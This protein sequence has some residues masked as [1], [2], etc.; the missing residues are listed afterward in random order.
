MKLHTKSSNFLLD[1]LFRRAIP[2]AFGIEML[3][4]RIFS[5]THTH[6]F[7]LP[8]LIQCEWKFSVL[9]T[10]PMLMEN[11]STHTYAFTSM[12]VYTNTYILYMR[13]SA[14]LKMHFMPSLTQDTRKKIQIQ[15]TTLCIQ[16]IRAQIYTSA[17]ALCCLHSSSSNNIIINTT[18]RKQL[19]I[20]CWKKKIQ[21]DFFYWKI[22]S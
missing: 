18:T 3:F 21:K 5:H 19:N 7:Y 17:I 10:F 11:R 14:V 2:L 8:Q 12:W 9:N 4:V 1:F 13:I 15:Y 16:K 20:C 6:S 22:Y